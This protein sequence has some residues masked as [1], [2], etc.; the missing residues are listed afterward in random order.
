MSASR[1]TSSRPDRWVQPRPHT[2]ASQ[3]LLTYGPIQPMQD[4][5]PGFFRRL[6]GRK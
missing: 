6:I 1:F 3:R 4:D 5:T 2:D